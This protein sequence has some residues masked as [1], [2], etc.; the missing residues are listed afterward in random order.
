[1]R[2]LSCS[3]EKYCFGWNNTTKGEYS[4][5]QGYL[6]LCHNNPNQSSD[7]F[8]QLWAQ[9]LW[10]KVR[11]FTW[12]L[13]HHRVL[14]GE[15]LMKHGFHG[16]FR[17]EMCEENVE[18]LNHIFVE[19]YLASELLRRMATLLGLQWSNFFTFE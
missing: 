14:T 11:F 4:I 7:I 17:C 2:S 19:C 13:L 5:A 15:Q 10:P 8:S 1:M 16:P 18:T 6:A 9:K 3:H 12:L